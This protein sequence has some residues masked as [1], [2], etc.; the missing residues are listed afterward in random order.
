MFHKTYSHELENKHIISIITA[1]IIIT[2]CAI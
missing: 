2:V 1:I